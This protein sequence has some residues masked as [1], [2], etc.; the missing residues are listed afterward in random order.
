VSPNF[1]VKI[2]DFGLAAVKEIENLET[3]DSEK[4]KVFGTPKYLAPEVWTG[5]PPNEKSDIYAYGLV[6]WE[7]FTRDTK[8]PYS[9][10]GSF[11]VRTFPPPILLFY[12][13]LTLSQH[14][15]NYFLG[16]C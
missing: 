4:K 5:S 12:F 14:W 13:S 9:R 10:Y 6:L 15:L 7:I 3:C 1:D 8:G 16:I 11:K 2:I